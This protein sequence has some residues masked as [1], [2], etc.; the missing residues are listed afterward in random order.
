[1][2][3]ATDRIGQNESSKPLIGDDKKLSNVLKSKSSDDEQ[4]S[5]NEEQQSTND[6]F[7]GLLNSTGENAI[8][9]KEKRLARRK[10]II[11]KIKLE[12]NH[13]KPFAAY[14]TVIK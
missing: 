13:I 4:D 1:M 6:L 2:N 7:G 8:E 12:E 3:T 14:A 9:M 10:E 11:S 5:D